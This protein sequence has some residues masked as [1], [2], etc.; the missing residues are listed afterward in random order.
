MTYKVLLRNTLTGN[1]TWFD[2]CYTPRKPKIDN[3]VLWKSPEDDIKV[4]YRIMAFRWEGRKDNFIPGL[5]QHKRANKKANEFLRCFNNKEL[6]SILNEIDH[7][8][9]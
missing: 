5:I 3:I 2:Q 7:V 1:K 6:H 8:S 9:I 4:K